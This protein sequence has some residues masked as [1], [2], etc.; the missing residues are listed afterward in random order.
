MAVITE[1]KIINDVL[2]E[3]SEENKPIILLIE[4][5]PDMRNYMRMF[6]QS[7][8]DVIE[9]NDGSSGIEKT[10]KYIPDIIICDVMMP[11]KDGFE[12]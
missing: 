10:I 2:S 6:L 8:Y 4:D 11:E 7:D 5:N 12:V 9:A 1:D 3:T